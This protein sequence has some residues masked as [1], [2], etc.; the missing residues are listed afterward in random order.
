MSAQASPSSTRRFALSEARSFGR[1][2]WPLLLRFAATSLLRTATAVAVIL[3]IRDFLGGVLSQPS[4]LASR[5][6]GTLERTSALWVVAGL[7]LAVFVVGA[8]C[9]YANEMAMQRL[10]RLLELDLMERLITHLLRMP[11]SFFDKRHRG[12]LIESVRQDVSKT[13]G[14][15]AAAVQMTVYG[16]QAVAYAG[17]AALISPRLT[18]ISLPVLFIAAAPGKWLAGHMRRGSFRIRTRGYRL[19][20]LLLQLLHGIRI[21]KVYAGEEA[22]T[23]NSITTARRYFDEMVA[24]ARVA[25]LGEV[26]LETAAGLSVVMVIVIG[27]F[28]VMN[29]R[30]SLPSLVALLIAIRAA[31]GPLNNCFAQFVEIQRNWASVERFRELMQTEPDLCDRPDALPLV[32]PIESLRFDNVSFAYDAGPRVLTDVSFEVRTGQH[33]G[34]VGPSGAGKTTLIGLVARFY[35][36]IE[37]RVLLNGRDLRAYRRSDFYRHLALVTQDIFVFGTSVR[38]NIRYGCMDASDADVEKAAVAAEIHDDIMQLPRGYDTVLGIGGRLLSVGQVQR[39][40]IARA[41][42]KNAV[43]VILDEATSNLDSISEAKIQAAL[44]R[45]M[46]GRTTF[47]IA[48][49][50]STLRKADLILVMDQGR[51]VACGAHATLLRDCAVYRDLW[52]AQQVS[53]GAFPQMSSDH[54]FVLGQSGR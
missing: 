42:L 1:A 2:Q 46:S 4:G 28:D 6:T 30:L 53:L 26:I 34:I 50:L 43:M 12:D 40:S 13:R 44:E 14:A 32:E 45:L 31:H 18:F 29:G 41:F 49:R 17:S 24:V 51:C 21:V 7:L 52:E 47:T 15:A 3:L 54:D 5:L 23:R 33:V 25:A 10:I 20:D 8:L 9:A 35:D 11:V 36:P 16:A 37:G 22:E 19:T 38:E 39:V 27:G 48:H